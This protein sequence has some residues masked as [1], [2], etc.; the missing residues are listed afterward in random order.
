MAEAAPVQP[1][2]ARPTRGRSIAAALC[3][4]LAA[5]LTVPASFAYWGQRTINDGSR[6]VAT[7]GPL[8]DFRKAWDRAR[9]AAGIRWPALRRSA[10]QRSPERD[11]LG[12]P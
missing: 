4:V 11:S 3:L 6:Y 12:C 5:V 1:P 7:V 8:G 9:K 10:A 2:A